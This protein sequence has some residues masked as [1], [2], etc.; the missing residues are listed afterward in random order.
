MSHFVP[1]RGW[2]PDPRGVDRND[3]KAVA[4]Y[5][6]RYKE[7]YDKPIRDEGPRKP[8]REVVT[9]PTRDLNDDR[10]WSGGSR[11]FDERT[12]TYRPGHRGGKIDPRL[13][14]DDGPAGGG[15]GLPN[16]KKT[17]GRNQGETIDLRK[18]LK[19]ED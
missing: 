4:D 8:E 7:F 5:E 18:V 14:I 17:G 10:V 15:R 3:P 2:E 9:K 6:R 1:G 19:K 16:L 12:G 13:G 11:D